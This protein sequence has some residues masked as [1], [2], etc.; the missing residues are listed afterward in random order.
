MTRASTGVSSSA[1]RA[2]FFPAGPVSPCVPGGWD[3]GLDQWACMG[4]GR[5][6]LAVAVAA[7]GVGRGKRG[8]PTWALTR[9]PGPGV[10]PPARVREALARIRTGGPVTKR[11]LQPELP[12]WAPEV[13]GG[14]PLPP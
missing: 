3:V 11:C 13:G 12:P 5:R 4:R 1:A 2:K 7:L 9:D 6:G 8:A 14:H 10:S